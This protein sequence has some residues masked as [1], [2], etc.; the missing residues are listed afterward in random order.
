MS[1]VATCAFC[2]QIAFPLALNISKSS[3]GTF[4]PLGRHKGLDAKLS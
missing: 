4:Y 1:T 2:L 3:A